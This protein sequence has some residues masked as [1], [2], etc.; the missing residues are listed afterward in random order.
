MEKLRVRKISPY[1]TRTCVV[2][3][4]TLHESFGLNTDGASIDAHSLGVFVIKVNNNFVSRPNQTTNIEEA[5]LHLTSREN[6]YGAVYNRYFDGQEKPFEL[7]RGAFFTAKINQITRYEYLPEK[8]TELSMYHCLAS[9][10][11]RLDCYENAKLCSPYSTPTDQPP[12]CK[13]LYK[14]PKH[15]QKCIGSFNKMYNSM[16]QECSGL[17]PCL[18]KEYVGEEYDLWTSKPYDQNKNDLILKMLVNQKVYDKIL[19]MVN[20][21]FMLMPM[22]GYPRW[23]RGEYR[24]GIQVEVHKEYQALTGISLVANIGGYFGLFVGFS[25]SGFVTSLRDVAP[26]VYRFLSK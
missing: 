24:G 26:Q 10:M 1:T 14:S 17:T 4:M 13:K 6:M 12:I 3:V 8:C 16:L 23:S 11:A 2:L 22:I 19:P 20:D 21:S 25:F 9:K 15:K 7:L 18:I 5:S